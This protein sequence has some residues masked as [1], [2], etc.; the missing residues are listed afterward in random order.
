MKR[1]P[2]KIFHFLHSQNFVVT[3][4]IG[5]DGIPHNSCKGILKVDRNCCVYLL[6]LYKAQTFKNLKHNSNI[7]ITVVDE[8]RFQGYCL[9]GKAKIVE[10]DKISPDILRTWEKKIVQ[11]ITNRVIKNIKGEKGHVS[12]PESLLPK[13]EY[14]IIVDV[15]QIVDLTPQQLK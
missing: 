6:D 14:M 5:R 10:I 8:H 9:K 4:T 2:E 3:S 1:I 12:H 13:P 11:R 15:N 7:S